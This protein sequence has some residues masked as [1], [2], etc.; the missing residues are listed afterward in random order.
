LLGLQGIEAIARHMFDS[1][2]VD[3]EPLQ[4]DQ[5]LQTIHDGDPPAGD[6]IWQRMSVMH[7]WLLMVQDVV[8]AYYAHPYAW[9]E[10][11]FGGP[12]YPRAYIRLENGRPEPWEV[13][14]Q[15]YEWEAPAN[16]LSGEY[17][18][19]GKEAEHRHQTPGQ[20]GTH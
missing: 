10:I 16:S 19:L 12:A 3:L 1:A 15:R 18:P 11:G 7:Y 13:D 17:R 5:V 6:D 14:E 8:D 20:E 2:F 9:D 4:Q